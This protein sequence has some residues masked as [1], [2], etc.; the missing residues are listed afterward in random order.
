MA[1]APKSAPSAIPTVTLKQIGTQIST[2]RGT[3]RKEVEAIL[4]RLVEVISDH[5]KGGSKVSING[6]GILQVKDLP[7]R[8]GRNPGTGATIDIAASKKVGFRVSKALKET[9]AA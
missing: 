2:E 6:L 9:V 5:V 8:T 7:A 1:V 3:P 4:T